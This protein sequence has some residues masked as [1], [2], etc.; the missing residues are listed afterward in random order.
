MHPANLS[1]K[2]KSLLDKLDLAGIE[3]NYLLAQKE[4]ND[5]NEYQS[6]RHTALLTLQK[7]KEDADSYFENLMLNDKYKNHKREDFYQIHIDPS[8][9][10][11]TQISLA[12][13]LGTYYSIEKNKSAIRG[14]S[15]QFLNNYFWAGDE[16]IKENIINVNQEFHGLELGYAYAFYEPPYSIKGS[17]IEKEEYFKEVEQEFFERFDM[18]AQI[19]R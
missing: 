11:G 8:K 4:E 16:E 5:S 9:L 19:W 14:R 2:Q 10:S 3:V 1:K 13:F 15:S 17:A 6:H 7:L 18:D 12:Q